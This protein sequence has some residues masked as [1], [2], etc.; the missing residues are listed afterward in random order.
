M[1]TLA[2]GASVL[3]VLGILAWCVWWVRQGGV[4]AERKR[5]AINA[6]KLEADARK[7]ARAD[8]RA[9]IDAAAAHR[10]DQTARPAVDRANDRLRK[11]GIIP[12]I[13]LALAWPAGAQAKCVD[14]G[15]HATCSSAEF[16]ALMDALDE[17]DEAAAKER[18]ARERAERELAAARVK[19]LATCPPPEA[20]VIPVVITAAIGLAV[21]A[22]ALVAGFASG[23]AR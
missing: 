8:E 19:E 9:A 4:D 13:V 23:L 21:A 15:T 20:P 5:Q 10:K 11:R 17:A 14:D 3:F 1:Q 7:D 16:A 6:A 12:A 18:A 22:V 2:V